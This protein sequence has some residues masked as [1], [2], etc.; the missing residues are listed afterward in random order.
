L[1]A[2]REDRIA[3]AGLDVV[4][5]EPFQTAEEART[6]NIIVTCHAAFCSVESKLEM[7]AI[8]AR[9]ALGAVTGLP[10]ENVVNGVI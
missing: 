7:R 4:E 3:G 6:P 1:A 5:D 9:I 10:L 8:S 2:L